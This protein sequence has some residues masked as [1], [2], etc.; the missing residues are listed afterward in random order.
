MNKSVTVSKTDIRLGKRNQCRKCPVAIA[1]CR[2]VKPNVVVSIGH[3]LG[4]WING[5]E[6]GRLVEAEMPE[7][8][9][10]WVYRYDNNHHVEP[11][12]FN[13]NIPDEAAA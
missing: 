12:T 7:E 11:M 4:F 9:L 1:L 8:V 6:H 3:A 13:V 2:H 10:D 5:Y